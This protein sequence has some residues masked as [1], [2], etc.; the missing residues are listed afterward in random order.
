MGPMLGGIKL[1]AN[2][3]GTWLGGG[4]KY[5]L[6]SPRTLGKITQLTHIFQ[7]GCSH[8]LVGIMV[9]YLEDHPMTCKWLTTMVSFRA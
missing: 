2:F 6:F 3:Y 1:D 9:Q 4:L 8:Q 5:F 7:M